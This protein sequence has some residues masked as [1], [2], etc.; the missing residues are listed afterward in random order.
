MG[1]VKGP[2]V[3]QRG[4]GWRREWMARAS[5]FGYSWWKCIVGFQLIFL[6]RVGNGPMSKWFLLDDTGPNSCNYCSHLALGQVT[7][8]PTAKAWD[9]IKPL[10]LFSLVIKIPGYDEV[11]C[12]T[13]A[14]YLFAINWLGSII[15]QSYTF[16]VFPGF[17]T[18]FQG[19]FK[20]MIP[21]NALHFLFINTKLFSC[22]L[23]TIM[24]K[25][26][27]RKENFILG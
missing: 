19:T 7:C 10:L 21:N 6:R 8:N 2:E 17:G 23:S 1:W 22:G 5:Y 15:M 3:W 13:L 16:I 9:G 27:L 20:H 26:R 14:S 24:G 18:S 25:L 4:W 12:Y 11:S